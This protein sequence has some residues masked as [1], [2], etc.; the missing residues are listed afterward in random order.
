VAFVGVA[1][2]GIPLKP[3]YGMDK[4]GI[5]A[6]ATRQSMDYKSNRTIHPGK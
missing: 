4:K 5:E 6:V 1:R 3:E 2:M